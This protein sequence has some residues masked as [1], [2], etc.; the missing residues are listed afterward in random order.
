MVEKIIDRPVQVEK[1]VE[2]PVAVPYVV[3]KPVHIPIQVGDLRNSAVF[4]RFL[5]N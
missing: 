5:R 1:I 4:T 3:E 2:K